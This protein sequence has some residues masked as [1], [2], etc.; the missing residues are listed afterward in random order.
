MLS[1][2]KSKEEAHMF[3]KRLIT[4]IVLLAIGITLIVYGI[5]ISQERPI[6]P[7]EDWLHK[8][9]HFFQNLWEK[10]TDHPKKEPSKFTEKSIGLLISGILIALGGAVQFYRGIK[11]S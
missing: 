8:I 3:N 9:G 4:G 1:R 11:K 2:R 7:P 10:I 6:E 5:H